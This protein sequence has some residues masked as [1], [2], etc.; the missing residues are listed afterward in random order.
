MSRKPTA[1]TPSA[2]WIASWDAVDMDLTSVDP[3]QAPVELG[4][5]CAGE[6]WGFV[7]I[8]AVDSATGAFTMTLSQVENHSSYGGV[9]IWSQPM[10]FAAQGR[11]MSPDN[12][13]GLYLAYP[14]GTYF[15][16]DLRG[17]SKSATARFHIALSALG[18]GTQVVMIRHHAARIT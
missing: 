8:M 12:A 4:D 18:T 9:V 3:D 1:P 15:A 14:N 6:T 11:R 10:T 16:F 5:I 17:V 13:S 7:P 2:P